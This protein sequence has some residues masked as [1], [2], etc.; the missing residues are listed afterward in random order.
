MNEKKDDAVPRSLRQV[1][2]WKEAIYQDVRRMPLDQAIDAVLDMAARAGD[3][4]DF[5]PRTSN[6]TERAR[7]AEAKSEYTTRKGSRP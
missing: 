2:E 5:L 6:S 7:V 3:K 1:W 4:C